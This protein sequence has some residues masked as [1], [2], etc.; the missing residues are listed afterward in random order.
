MLL[1]TVHSQRWL[2]TSVSRKVTMRT[3]ASTK[4]AFRLLLLWGLLAVQWSSIIPSMLRWTWWTQLR[5][6]IL[7]MWSWVTFQL[8]LFLQKFFLTLV[9]HIVSWQDHLF[10]SITSFRKCW[11]NP[12]ELFLRALLWGLPRWFRM[13]PSRWATVDFCLLQWFLVTLILI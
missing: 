10:N 4:G 13:F 5:Q 9:H 6:R 8:T 3:S 12:W 2:A 7:Q 11:E 1:I